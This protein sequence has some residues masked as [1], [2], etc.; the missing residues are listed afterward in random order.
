MILCRRAA[1][2]CLFRVLPGGRV[3]RVIGMMAMMIRWK[4]GW[5]EK[6]RTTERLER[7]LACKT[8]RLG[9]MRMRGKRG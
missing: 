8:G 3:E 5:I 2:L 9:G 7:G 4:G 1:L 6:D